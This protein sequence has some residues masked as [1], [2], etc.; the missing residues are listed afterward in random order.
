MFAANGQLFMERGR[1]QTRHVIIKIK[2]SDICFQLLQRI[3]NK[4]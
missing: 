1:P 4:I 3:T 2:I